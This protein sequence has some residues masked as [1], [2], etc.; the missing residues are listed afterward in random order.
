MANDIRIVFKQVSE[1]AL[2]HHWKHPSQI[3]TRK[4]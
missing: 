2:Q 1:F 3:Q 4:A